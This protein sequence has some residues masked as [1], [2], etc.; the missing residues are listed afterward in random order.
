MV[1]KALD[2]L[3]RARETGSGPLGLAL[4]PAFSPGRGRQLRAYFEAEEVGGAGNGRRQGIT[5]RSGDGAGAEPIRNGNPIDA[6]AAA[7]NAIAAARSGRP[8]ESGRAARGNFAT[9]LKVRQRIGWAG[10]S[11]KFCV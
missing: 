2:P 11:Y 1:G 9:D 7:Q 4:T 10:A 6:I 5:H 3:P 8:G